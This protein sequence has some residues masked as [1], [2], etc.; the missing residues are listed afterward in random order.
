MLIDIMIKKA[1]EFA[2][3][4]EQEPRAIN[5]DFIRPV[6]LGSYVSIWENKR[7]RQLLLTDTETGKAHTLAT[8][9]F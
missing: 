4:E 5:I 8:Y 7:S 2:T 6:T 9:D 1:K 3:F